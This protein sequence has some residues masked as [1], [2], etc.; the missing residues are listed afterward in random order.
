M[1][2]GIGVEIDGGAIEYRKELIKYTTRLGFKFKYARNDARYVFAVCS[3][4]N[5]PW[6]IKAK[7]QTVTKKFVIYECNLIHECFGDLVAQKKSRFGVKIIGDLVM[8]SVRAN[9]T[10]IPKEVIRFLKNSYGLDIVYWKA[11]RIIESARNQIFG[12]YDESY[13]HLRWYCEAIQRTNLGSVVDLQKNSETQHFERV[14]NAFKACIDGFKRCRSMLFI[15]DT[16]LKGRAK[17]TMLSATAK[18]GNNG[19]FPVAFAIVSSE[20]TENLT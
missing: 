19:L 17:G 2:D 18:D 6:F 5:S 10:I 8:R 14:F 12:S 1:K 7:S 20:N 15:D 9:P 16:F 4:D 11:W 13:E 3:E